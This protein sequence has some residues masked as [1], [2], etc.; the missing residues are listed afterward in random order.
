[1]LH[2]ECCAQ[3]WPP[4]LKK[5]IAKLEKVHKR[6]TKMIKGL[7]YIP[8]ETR[9]KH[10]GLFNLEKRQLSIDIVNVHKSMHGVEKVDRK[11]FSF[12]SHKISVKGYCDIPH[13]DSQRGGQT[14]VR[15]PTC[16]EI[17][18]GSLP[19]TLLLER[20]LPLLGLGQ[21]IWDAH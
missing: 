20:R 1:M 10:L 2:L 17:Q 15:N 21:L 7:E 18:P 4:C 3:F 8:Y 14:K 5:G 19:L 6:A 12:L 13:W 9:L 11:I 16:R